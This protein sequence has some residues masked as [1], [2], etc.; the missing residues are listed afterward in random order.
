MHPPVGRVQAPVLAAGSGA[1]GVGAGTGREAL[2]RVA[3]ARGLDG[4]VEGE[5]IGLLGDRRDLLG[6]LSDLVDLAGEQFPFVVDAR[7]GVG[8]LGQIDVPGGPSRR[9]LHRLRRRIPPLGKRPP[10]GEARKKRSGSR[11]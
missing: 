6:D 11:P 8:E 5:Q 9:R 7:D 2:A 3:R 1:A 4:G 10:C